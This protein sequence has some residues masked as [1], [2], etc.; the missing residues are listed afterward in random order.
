MWNL[1]LAEVFTG[2]FTFKLVLLGVSFLV[3][4]LC[5]GGEVAF[6]GF[7]RLRRRQLEAEGH[8]RSA[9]VERLLARPQRFLITL[10]IL[11]TLA[12]ILAG[13]L[14]GSLAV[15]VARA[16]GWA[17]PTLAGVLTGLVTLVV[18]TFSEITPKAYAAQNNE[19]L[20]LLLA[21]VFLLLMRLLWPLVLLFDRF[22]QVIFRLFRAQATEGNAGF[23]SEQELKTLVTMG[24]EEGVLE[25]LKEEMIHGVIELGDTRVREIMVPRID[26]AAVNADETLGEAR[27]HVVETGYSRIPV[28]QENLDDVVGV[29]VLKDF[30]L[31]LTEGQHERKVRDIMRE[32]LFVPESMRVDDLL[33]EMQAR[34]NH[35]AIVVDEFGGTAGLVTMEDVL[36]EIVGEIFDEYDLREHPI[37]KVNDHETIVDARLHVEEL[38]E[39]LDLH[40]PTE[41]PFDTVA[42]FV[43]HRLGRLGKEG[44]RVSV[45]GCELVVEKV[46]NRRI[47]RVRIVTAG[48]EAEPGHEAPA[49]R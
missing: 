25:E 22:T 30:L 37:R 7:S 6:V 41:G 40:L 31:A 26:M 11:N 44:E 3:S 33:K 35:M 2:A 5:S 16:T 39:A 45:D 10:L 12:N 27:P 48:A 14:A 13:F 42:G 24:A 23:R 43:Y 32:A 18:L 34:R 9:A 8:P 29:M 15:D 36:E 19:R 4:A 17:E 20:S 28:Y 47:V 46:T 38:N 21:P 49:P 1:A